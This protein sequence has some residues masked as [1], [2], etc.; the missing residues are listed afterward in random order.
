M[1]SILAWGVLPPLALIFYIWSLDRIEKEPPTLVIKTMLFGAGSA[2][3][4]VAL[5]TAGEVIL[6]YIGTD[7]I[8]DLILYYFIVVAV[9][10]E[11]SKRLGMKLAVWNNP[12]FNFRFD[13][14]IYSVASAL[15]FAALENVLYMAS[16]GTQIALSRLI[17]VHS[18]CGVFMG[19]YL[20][21]AKTAELDGDNRSRS[22]YMKLSLIVPVLIHGFYDFCLSTG[23][24]FLSYFVLGCIFIL[25]IVAWRKLKTYA[26]IDRPS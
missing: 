10:E 21:I 12:N 13:A 19:Y 11:F 25:A 16:Y 18:I 9:S 2:I 7:G 3:L 1:N 17:P 5:E 20:G 26:K 23:D 6:E 4:A 24:A 22:I 15:G 8:L 14:V